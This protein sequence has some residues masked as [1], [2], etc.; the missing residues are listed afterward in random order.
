MRTAPNSAA[1]SKAA[2]TRPGSPGGRTRP[3]AQGADP[4]TL[5]AILQDDSWAVLEVVHLPNL[6][7]AFP[8]SASKEP[9]TPTMRCRA[10]VGPQ[11]QRRSRTFPAI[12]CEVNRARAGSRRHDPGGPAAD[13]ARIGPKSGA[14]KSRTPQAKHSLPSPFHNPAE[15]ATPPAALLAARSRTQKARRSLQPVPDLATTRQYPVRL[16]LGPPCSSFQAIGTPS[17]LRMYR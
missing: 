16:P 8:A 14:T 9:G 2:I 3:R 11:T 4:G 6:T 5:A 12:P 10:L 1:T 15:E 7:V 13:H 17:K